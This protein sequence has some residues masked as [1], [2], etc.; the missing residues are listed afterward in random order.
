M[1][2]NFYQ[3]D[4]VLHKAIAPL[5]MKV[6]EEG[7]KTF[8]YCQ[9]EQQVKEIDDGLWQFSKTK[10]VPHATKS[11]KLDPLTQPIFIDCAPKNSNQ[12]DYLLMFD[13]VE[14]KFL[15]DFKKVFYFFG[16]GN[17]GEARKLWSQYKKQSCV[18][19]FYKKEDQS[20]VKVN[21]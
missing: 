12:A 4:D 2:I 10:F 15:A 19:N 6:L 8:I 3:V 11:E 20:W 16:S 1:E 7:K 14:E 17:V 21:L 9:N 18:L 13:A 5:L